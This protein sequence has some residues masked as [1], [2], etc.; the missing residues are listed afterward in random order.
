[1]SG[2]GA[3]ASGLVARCVGG[4]GGAAEFE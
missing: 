4:V 3:F 1:L 2:L